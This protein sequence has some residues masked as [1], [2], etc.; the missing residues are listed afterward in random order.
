MTGRVGAS[1]RGLLVFAAAT[2]VALPAA[3]NRGSRGQARYVAAGNAERGP[4]A[5]RRYG[6]GSCHVVPGIREA[7]GQVGPALDH[8][9]LRTYV[10]GMLPNTSENLVHWIAKPQEVQPGNAMPNLGVTDREARDIAA[11]LYTLR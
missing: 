8:Y 7:N 4:A 10:A 3:C 9:A 6:C 11:Y 2:V 1:V 5:I